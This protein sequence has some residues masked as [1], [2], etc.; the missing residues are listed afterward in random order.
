[1]ILGGLA[2]VLILADFHYNALGVVRSSLSAVATPFYWLANAPSRMATWTEENWGREE[3]LEE[4]NDRLKQ[5]AFILNG[6]M[7]KMS[8]LVADN[9]RLRE[10]LNSTALLKSDDVLIAET[11][12]VS[13]RPDQ[14]IIVIDK[15]SDNQV[16]V[17]QPVIDAEGLMGQVVEVNPIS[18]R[19]LLIA[20]SSHAVPVQNNRNGMRSVAEGT[21]RLDELELRHV[22][23]TTDIKQGDLLVTSGLGGRFPVGY[24]VA[25]VTSVIH[26]PGQPFLTVKAKP[27]AKLSQ[28]RHV[29]IVF[30]S[31]RKQLPQ[32]KLAP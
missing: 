32:D 5:E 1:M 29:L 23:A 25:E 3:S 20:D 7:L 15:G 12:G 11:I 8:A 10:L 19:I 22:A 26:D 21:G 2:L 30:S 17:G 16:S 6:R 14:H 24:P 31:T 28:S 18:A 27:T 9:G 13:P 4:E